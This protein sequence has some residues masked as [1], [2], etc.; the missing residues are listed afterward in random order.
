MSREQN[1]LEIKV[2]E[3]TDQLVTRMNSNVAQAEVKGIHLDYSSTRIVADTDM[4]GYSSLYLRSNG[5]WVL[6]VGMDGYPIGRPSVTK[7]LE[8]F[9]TITE[10]DSKS[11]L[12]VDFGAK[13]GQK[14][15]YLRENK[16]RLLKG[17]S[18]VLETRL[19]EVPQL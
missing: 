18:E 10:P 16:E 17:F 7:L 9:A 1:P 13:P 4:E 12:S 19:Q 3:L 2:K 6:R 5:E 8:E 14:A 11:K 15:R